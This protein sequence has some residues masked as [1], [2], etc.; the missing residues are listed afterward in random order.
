M[1]KISFGGFLPKDFLR[2]YTFVEGGVGFGD[3]NGAF[4]LN[5]LFGDG[6]GMDLFF[7]KKFQYICRLVIYSIT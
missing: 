7:N 1:E 4:A 3:D 5:I 6:G 2:S